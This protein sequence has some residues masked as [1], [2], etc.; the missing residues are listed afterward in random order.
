MIRSKALI[1]KSFWGIKRPNDFDVNQKRSPK[2]ISHRNI[3]VP[4]GIDAKCFKS[5]NEFRNQFIVLA[6]TFEKK[7]FQVYDIDILVWN[8]FG[9]YKHFF[10]T[11]KSVST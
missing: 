6:I 9:N 1:F 3:L 5:N 7:P 8:F 2:F 4:I 11:L 10:Q